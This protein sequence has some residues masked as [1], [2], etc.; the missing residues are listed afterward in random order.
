LGYIEEYE[1]MRR[2][3]DGHI[4]LAIARLESPQEKNMGLEYLILE[5]CGHI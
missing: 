1:S 5:I 4:A 2:K 3:R